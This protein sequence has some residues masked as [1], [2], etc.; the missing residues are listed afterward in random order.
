MNL[1]ADLLGLGEAAV[2]AGL[3][4]MRALEQAAPGRQASGSMIRLVV[5][6]TASFQLLPATIALLRAQ[7]GSTAPLEI[8]PAVWLTS[9]LSVGAGLLRRFCWNGGGNMTG[10]CCCRCCSVEPLDGGSFRGW[11]CLQPFA[12]GQPR[13]SRLLARSCP[14]WWHW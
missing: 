6:N 4:A 1:T 11:M 2:P 14:R 8:L 9:L 3:E 10:V 12:P 13:G 7:H 5:L